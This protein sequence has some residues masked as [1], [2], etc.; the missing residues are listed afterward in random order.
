MQSQS[1]ACLDT[2][3]SEISASRVRASNKFAFD[4][5]REYLGSKYVYF[6]YLTFEL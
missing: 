5:L 6:E 3:F 2:Y 4:A 1:K